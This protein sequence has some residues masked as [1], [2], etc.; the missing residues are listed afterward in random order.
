MN[1]NNRNKQ[2]ALTFVSRIPEFQS[3]LSLV[4]EFLASLGVYQEK[5]LIPFLR[6][7]ELLFIEPAV[8]G[9]AWS[10]GSTFRQ[11]SPADIP[12]FIEDIKSGDYDAYF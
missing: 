5:G 7:T 10:L 12:L 9:R 2:N 4:D 8:G 3:Q 1:E 6:E 11:L